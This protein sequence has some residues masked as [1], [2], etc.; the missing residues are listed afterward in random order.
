VTRLEDRKKCE[1]KSIPVK[2]TY[3]DVCGS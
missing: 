2:M 3:F 1:H